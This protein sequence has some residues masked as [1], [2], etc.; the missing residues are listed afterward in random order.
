METVKACRW[1]Q[2]D[3]IITATVSQIWSSKTRHGVAIVAI[4]FSVTTTVLQYLRIYIQYSIKLN[5]ATIATKIKSFSMSRV[6]YF[7]FTVVTFAQILKL[8]LKVSNIFTHA[9][10]SRGSKAFIAVCASVCLSVCVC[11][12]VLCPHDRTKMAAW[13]YN[14]QIY[15]RDSPLWVMATHVILGQKVKGQGHRVTKCKNIEGDLMTGVSLRSIE[16]QSSKSRL[17]LL[18]LKY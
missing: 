11:V 9:D 18:L 8:L 5:S 10:N 4:V 17:L 12:C 13:N 6:F 3:F 15:H 16:C 2:D 14:H 7:Y 1:L